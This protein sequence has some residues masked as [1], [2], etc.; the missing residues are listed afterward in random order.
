[1]EMIYY[2]ILFASSI[3]GIYDILNEWKNN[4]WGL[5]IIGH[6]LYDYQ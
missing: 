4:N 5:W 3:I 6:C 2:T 1:M